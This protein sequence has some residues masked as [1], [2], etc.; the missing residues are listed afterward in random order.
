MTFHPFESDPL[1]SWDAAHSAGLEGL[2]RHRRAHGPEEE[3]CKAMARLESISRSAMRQCLHECGWRVG[4]SVPRQRVPAKVGAAPRHTVLLNAWITALLEA[5][6]LEERADGCRWR[7]ETEPFPAGVESLIQAL[8]ASYDQLGFPPIMAEVHARALARLP[9]LVRDRV[10][11]EEL[12]FRDGKV[13]ESLGAYQDNLF[14]SYLNAACGHLARCLADELPAPLRMME[15]GGGAGLTSGAVLGALDGVELDYLF[16]DLSRMFTVAA[17]QRFAGQPGLRCGPLDINRPF[18]GQGERAA[19]YDLVLAGNVLHNAH[20]LG[21]TLSYIRELLAPGGWLLFTESCR[22][23]HAVLTCMQFLLSPASGAPAPGTADRRGN[24]GS[25]F[26]PVGDWQ[27]QLRET[28]FEPLLTL[29][30]EGVPLASAGQHLFLAR[31]G[32]GK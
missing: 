12:L 30:A 26:L 16:S 14:T 9:Q 2:C 24:T 21:H 19:S 25:L 23:N 10:R 20:D 6:S 8:D 3:I 29:P 28:G 32:A 13:L 1:V 17:A 11:I 4:E 15:L 18:T 22:D 5:G 31:L 7:A 27:M